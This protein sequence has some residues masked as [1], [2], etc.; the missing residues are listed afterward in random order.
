MQQVIILFFS[1]ILTLFGLNQKIVK[2]KIC[3]NCKHFIADDHDGSFG[4]CS[5][6]PQKK[7]NIDFLVHGIEKKEIVDYNY[8]STARMYDHMCG[9]EGKMYKKRNLKK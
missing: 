4:K 7:D 9:K 8:C 1:L 5:L 3:I 6:F 2:P